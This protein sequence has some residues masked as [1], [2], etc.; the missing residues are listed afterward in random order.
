MVLNLNIKELL[1]SVK[2]SLLERQKGLFFQLVREKIQRRSSVKR[3]HW[4]REG[5]PR[6]DVNQRRVAEPAIF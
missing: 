4:G 6:C 5:E 2:W 3:K 1:H